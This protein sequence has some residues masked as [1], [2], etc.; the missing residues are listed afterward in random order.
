MESNPFR[1][2]P[3]PKLPLLVIVWKE[4]NLP[5][6]SKDGA[7]MRGAVGGELKARISYL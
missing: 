6:V 7:E 3:N 2:Y 5:F 4:K 1:K